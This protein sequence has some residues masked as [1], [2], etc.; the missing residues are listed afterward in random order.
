MRNALVV[1]LLLVIFVLGRALVRVEN[2]RY[3]LWVGMCPNMSGT[4]GAMRAGDE[5]AWK[6]TKTIQT[7]TAWWWHVYDAISNT[8]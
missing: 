1:L 6:C 8:D 3:A 7:R 5:N 4:F 2:E